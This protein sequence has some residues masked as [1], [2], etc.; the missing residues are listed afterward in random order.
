MSKY[1]YL[2]LILGIILFGCTQNI[3][4]VHTQ[5]TAED[6]VDTD[7]S[8]KNDIKADLEIPLKPVGL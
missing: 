6:V 1:T 5:G 8:P 2:Y 7:Q 4:C 3:T